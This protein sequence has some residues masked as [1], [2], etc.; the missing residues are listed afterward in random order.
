[1]Q[2]TWVGFLVWEDPT[3]HRATK[4]VCHNYWA[5]MPQLLKP[6]CCRARVPQLVSPRAATTEAH[7]PRA[8]ALQWEAT[9]MRSPR[10]ATKSSPRSPQLEKAH[11]QQRRPNTAK[12]WKKKLITLIA[13]WTPYVFVMLLRVCLSC[14]IK[15]VSLPTLNFLKGQTNGSLRNRERKSRL[16]N[17]L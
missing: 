10:T 16:W 14:Y 6:A 9:T 5:C 3:C 7:A 11:A 15:Q 4:P 12:L 1:M 17:Y 8:C 13:R 2:G